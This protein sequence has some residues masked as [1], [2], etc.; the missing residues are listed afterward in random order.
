MSEIT[1]SRADVVVIGDGIIG[2]STALELARRGAACRVLG[3]PN[4]GIASLAAAGLLAP[5][6]GHLSPDVEPFYHAS[7]AAYPDFVRRLHQVDAELSLIV[8]LIDTSNGASLDGTSSVASAAARLLSAAQV[9]ALEPSLAAPAGGVL[10]EREA[11]IDNVRLHAALCTAAVRS[12][13]ITLDANAPIARVTFGGS[14]VAA[15]TRA[16]T[17]HEADRLLLAA[18]AWSP[19]IAGLPRPLPVEPLKGQMLA[20]GASPLRRS[21]MSAD[22]YLVPRGAETLVGATVE[23]AGF[24]LATDQASLDTLRR[25][26]L[27]LCP[28]LGA[29][30][31]TRSWAGIRPATP[32]LRPILG[33]DPD[34][35]RL[36]Y[37]CGHS[38]NGI[39]LAPATADALASLILGERVAQDL[40]PFSIERFGANQVANS[41]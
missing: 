13:A 31:V 23:R 2:L 9:A 37:A 21:V 16:G 28:A 35:P 26:A 39:L 22:V 12:P 20:L 17:V 27:R 8:G 19:A 34:E 41:H 1:D 5:S 40:T 38:K 18:G 7:L 25:A 6:I 24:D 33:P 10:Y 11:A 36:F 30:P 14:Q 32:D 15:V 4:A 29:A 3:A